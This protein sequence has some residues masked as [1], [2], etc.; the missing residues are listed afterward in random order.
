M[1]QEALAILL[2][3]TMTEALLVVSGIRDIWKKNYRDTGYFREKLK[4]YRICL[5]NISGY[6]VIKYCKFSQGIK[7]FL[8]FTVFASFSFCLFT[9]VFIHCLREKYMLAENACLT[10]SC[11]HKVFACIAQ[12]CWQG[13]QLVQTPPPPKRSIWKEPKMNLRKKGTPKMNFFF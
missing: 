10:S 12:A 13:E 2:P 11:F 8:F 4:G 1:Y 5:N 3:K 7:F 6:R 9:L